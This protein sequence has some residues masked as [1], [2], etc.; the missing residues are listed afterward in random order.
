MMDQRV[1]Y[2]NELCHYGIKGMKWGVRRYPKQ[3]GYKNIK[4]SKTS[5]LDKWGKDAEHNVVYIGGY[6][7]SGK[8]TVAKSLSNKFTDTIHL[9]LYFDSHSDGSEKRCE[10]FDNYLRKNKIK[11]PYEL[12]VKEWSN[13]KSLQKFENAIESFG[14]EQHK[15]GRKVIAE[16]IQVVDG[17]IRQDKKFFVDKP[18]ILLSTD[19]VTSMARAFNRNREENV[20]SSLRKKID[21]AKEH[22]AWYSQTHKQLTDM[23]K[24]TNAKSGE[25]W[26]KRYLKS[27]QL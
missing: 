21:S 9:D 19:P 10:A 3:L 5:N 20:S 14:Q 13:D 6:S 18:L 27:V 24:Q 22:I 23:I 8:S 15:K 26:V 12:T 11:K 16:G 25:K 17:G 4:K 7:G 1:L 2:R